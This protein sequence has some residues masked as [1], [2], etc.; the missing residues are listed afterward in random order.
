MNLLTSTEVAQ[1]LAISENTIR[2]SRVTGTL[3]GKPAPE[4]I[5]MGNRVRY[6]EQT[7]VGFIE[8]FTTHRN[9]AE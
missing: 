6:A 1:R 5:K 8:A 9:T 3:L 7:V 4:H 2:H